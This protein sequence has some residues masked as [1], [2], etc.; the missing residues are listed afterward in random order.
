[1]KE[2]KCTIV[3]R[4]DTLLSADV[5]GQHDVI[6]ANGGSETFI[7]FGPRVAVRLT[8][9]NGAL[10]AQCE[11]TGKKIVITQEAVDL[12]ESRPIVL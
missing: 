12:A 4:S 3:N 2:G 7:V 9:F 1:M 8:A 5:G 6:H 10:V 11:W